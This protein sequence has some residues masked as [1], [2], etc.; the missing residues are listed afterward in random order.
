MPAMNGREL[1]AQLVRDSFNIPTIMITAHRDAGLHQEDTG[2]VAFLS[3]PLQ[4]N[5][6]LAAINR[7]IDVQCE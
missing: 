5:A 6:L 1:Q 3:K 7:A 4:E 2:L